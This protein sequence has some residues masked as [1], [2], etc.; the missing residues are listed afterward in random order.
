MG[1]A[2]SSQRRV[3]HYQGAP[4]GEDN[5]ADG[6]TKH[7]ERRKMEMYTEKCVFVRCEG[8]DELR[9]HLGDV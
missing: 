9:P 1:A 7:V 3:V 5:V 4:S 6:L 8:R 2:E